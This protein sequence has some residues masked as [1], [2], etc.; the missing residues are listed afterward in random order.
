MFPYYLINDTI[1]GKKSLNTKC[2]F[3]F[4]LQLLFETFLIL[5]RTEWD[6]IKNVYWSSCKVPVILARLQWNLNFPD[7]FSKLH[8]YKISRKSAAQW[9]PRCS[10]RADRQTD[11][12]KLTVA[13]NSFENAPKNNTEHSQHL[14]YNWQEQTFWNTLHICEV[15]VETDLRI[16]EHGLGSSGSGYGPA[17]GS[18]ESTNVV[19][20]STKGAEH[21]AGCATI[22]FPRRSLHIN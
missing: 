6:M 4:S 9:G 10:M 5:R 20:G 12:T 21:G 2:V 13:F 19:T 7:I 22:S 3:W 18:S 1:S 11:M 16:R 8:K 15:N 14:L 17:T